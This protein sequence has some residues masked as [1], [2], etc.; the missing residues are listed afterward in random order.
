MKYTDEATYTNKGKE[1]VFKYIKNPSLTDKMQTVDDILNGVIN[2]T[3][4]YE[5]ILFNYFS[6]VAFIENLTNIKLPSSFA[7]SA[8]FIENTN[9]KE[10]LRECISND[11]LDEIL[12]AAKEKI[13]FKKAQIVNSSKLDELFGALATLVNKYTES[14][15]GIDVNDMLNKLSLVSEIANTPKEDIVSGILKFEDYKNKEKNISE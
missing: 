14:F 13:E 11:A 2:D 8:G 7:G 1:I 10:V 15:E 4:G 12:N 6:T 5:P 3:V 9:I